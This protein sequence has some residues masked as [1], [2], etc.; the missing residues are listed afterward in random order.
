LAFLVIVCQPFPNV[1]YKGQILADGELV[2]R[3]LTGAAVT[4]EQV[5][6]V[7]A[8]MI[9]ESHQAMKGDHKMLAN[10]TQL[11]DLNHIVK[12]PLQLCEGTRKSGV[13]L[14]FAMSIRV[15]QNYT[16]LESTIESDSSHPLVVMTNQK[17]WEACERTLLLRDAFMGQVCN[18]QT[19]QYDQ[20]IAVSNLSTITLY[21][22]AY[23]P[24]S[25]SLSLKA[26]D[27]MVSICQCTS[28]PICSFGQARSS[29]SNTL[30]IDL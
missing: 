30:L 12:F 29:Q 9:V 22:C 19:C 11:M 7:K 17:Q 2:L 14:R 16:T 23:M 10:D 5:S 25:L 8:A 28:T 4:V 26:R 18:N 15:T 20:V 21:V 6:P 1:F 27:S 3:L 13:H 24:L